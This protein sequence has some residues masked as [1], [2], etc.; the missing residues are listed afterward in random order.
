MHNFDKKDTQ[1][2]YRDQS[3]LG[4]VRR[5]KTL[6]TIMIL[7]LS[8]Q[9]AKSKQLEFGD[10][11]ENNP[12]V[13]EGS[14]LKV[15]VGCNGTGIS[16]ANVYL[17]REDLI[18]LHAKTNETGYATFDIPYVNFS[19]PCKLKALK[20]AYGSTELSIWVIDRPKLYILAPRVVEEGKE[21]EIRVIDQDLRGVPDAILSI[22]GEEILTNETGCCRYI[23]PQVGFST[24]VLLEA[25]KDGYEQSEEIKLWIADN[26]SSN[27]KA[28]LWVYEGE[29]FEI[30]YEG[31]GNVRIVFGDE[32]FE[33]SNVEIEAP[34]LNQTKVY[35]I[36][37]YDENNSLLDYRF[38]VILDRERRAILSSPSTVIE[39]ERFNVSL[40]SLESLEPI[41]GIKLRFYED[42]KLTD[43]NGS[44]EFE[45]PQINEDYKLFSIEVLDSNISCGTR[46]I[47]VEKP[48]ELS[49][50]IEG[51]STVKSGENVTYNV[52]DMSGNKVFAVLTVENTTFYA[53]NGTAEIKIPD[54]EES[55]FVYLTA[56]SPGYLKAQKMIYI[57]S[58]ERRLV[59]ECED[60]VNE[61]E[62]F[63]ILIKDQDGN[64]VKNATVWFNF[65]C[66]ETD[67][68]GEI[69]LI[70]PDVLL[71]T[72]YLIYVE[73]E[74]YLSAS[75][76]ITIMESGIGEKFLK[77]IA[78]LAL[79]PWQDF[80]VRVVNA[81]GEGIEG[82]DVEMR[83]G[84]IDVS[85]KTDEN[86]YL[87]MNAP[88]L[89]NDEY[90]TLIATK[91]GYV[92]DTILVRLLP[93]Y[94][95]LP[96]LV[97]TP[98]KTSLTEGEDFILQVKDENG[99]AV[100]GAEIWI[101]GE[102][103]QY[104]SDSNGIVACKAPYVEIDRSCFIYATKEGYNF[105]YTWVK[106][107]NRIEFEEPLD[108]EV[109]DTVYEG[110]RFDVVVRDSSGEPVQGIY[111]W[112]NSMKKKTNTSGMTSFVAPYVEKDSYKL[113]GIE[114]DEYVPSYRLIRVLDRYNEEP[115]LNISTPPKIFEGETI[116]IVVKDA[117]GYAVKDVTIIV[118]GQIIGSTD[119][120][121]KFHFEAPYVDHDST[122]EIIAIKSGY[123]SS[124][125][126]I[127]IK[128]REKGFFEEN[129]YLLPVIALVIM[130]AIFAYFRYRQYII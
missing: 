10:N 124:S 55:K 72:R 48:E 36:R 51:P 63:S 127:E 118:N 97:V 102:L 7:I 129:W 122:I 92:T 85:S 47:W 126:F 86:G 84:L 1:K 93:E 109:N 25:R 57:M 69:D 3:S 9:I 33:G 125:T 22:D 116:D 128:N 13:I 98:S 104:A 44:A 53:W 18:Q 83:Y 115:A 23:A 117:Y 26:R 108:I 113:I 42:T 75:K 101:D 111:V 77:I 71:S 59:V 88:P 29:Y 121:G 58:R 35:Q 112:F 99:K 45:A 105:G 130:I 52:T 96:S 28:P 114:S 49:L 67:E 123:I 31:E 95:N 94:P 120:S 62:S 40:L 37:V 32:T 43:I 50:S 8:V 21:I 61:G 19:I 66:Y 65:K 27:L 76:W 15:F 46:Y 6:I 70:A 64:P 24:Y 34:E 39:K 73:K 4:M 5:A 54:V 81:E 60:S 78:P 14:E 119:E 79:H 107:I 41:Q 90:I 20:Q 87:E 106:V 80:E 82:V 68:N 2:I 91:D 17:E 89:G 103:Y 110:D 16:D 56:R 74:G 38:V 100:E 30:R 12:F 11:I